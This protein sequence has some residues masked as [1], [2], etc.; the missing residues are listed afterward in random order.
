MSRGVDAAKEVRNELKKMGISS[1]QVSV[2]NDGNGLNIRIKDF[3]IAA[4]KVAEVAKRFEKIDY[5]PI[6]QEI[7]C[8]GNYFVSV[9]YDWQE[10][11]RIKK[12]P[13]FIAL[14]EK[15]AQKLQ[16]IEGNR[17]IELIE[18]YTAF[19]AQN[20]WSYQASIEYKPENYWHHFSDAEDIA[21]D[22]YKDK[23]QGRIKSIDL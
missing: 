17:G 5:C 9:V 13:E 11:S 3:A 16:T 21:L 20:G 6:T 7:L 22:L 10:E 4:E 8:G 19:K 1:R 14:K 23:V 12:T 18:G 2:R 15:I